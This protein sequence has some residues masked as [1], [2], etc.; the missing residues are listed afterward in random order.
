MLASTLPDAG[1]ERL[2]DQGEVEIGGRA[3]ARHRLRRP[4]LQPAGASS[5]PAG[6]ARERRPQRRL[7]RGPR[8]PAR[9]AD[10]RLRVRAHRLALAAGPDPAP[11]RR[12]AQ[13]RPPATSASR[14]RPRATTSSPRSASS[15]TRWRA[16]SRSGWRSSQL[17]RKRLREAIRRVGQSFAKGLERDALLEIV[18]QTAVDGVGADAGRAAV[19]T[20]PQ[21][22]LR[23]GRGRGRRRALPR[24]DQRRRGRRAGRRGRRGDRARNGHFALSH[25]LRAQEGGRI[26]GMLSVARD[27]N[28]VHRRRAGAV[29]LPLPARPASRSRTSTCTRRSSARRS[30]TS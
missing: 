20:T 9:G 23:G 22:P 6:R 8:D 21:R 19:R 27:T 13:A 30:P 3:A 26:L 4:R 28:G 29:Q 5:A 2:P 11:A 17:E 18:V 15:S 25:P 10:R 24:R 1:A 14:C 12:G 16:S 7:D